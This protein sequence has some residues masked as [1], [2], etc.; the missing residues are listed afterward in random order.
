MIS[1]IPVNTFFLSYNWYGPKYINGQSNEDKE[2]LKNGEKDGQ[3]IR[4][5]KY[6]RSVASTFG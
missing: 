5:K 4:R 1:K 3:V 6:L 2:P